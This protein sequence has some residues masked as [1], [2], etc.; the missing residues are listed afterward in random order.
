MFYGLQHLFFVKVKQKVTL[1]NTLNNPNTMLFEETFQSVV[2]ELP[3]IE[4][5]NENESEV[6]NFKV[7]DSPLCV[8]TTLYEDLNGGI[9][10]II[11]EKDREWVAE[12]ELAQNKKWSHF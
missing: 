1:L 8:T 3:P 12:K 9:R 5:F 2:S 6:L 11:T 7:P 10:P 4:I